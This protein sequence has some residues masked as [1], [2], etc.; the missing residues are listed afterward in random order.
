LTSFDGRFVKNLNGRIYVGWNI[1]T[2]YLLDVQGSAWNVVY[3]WNPI[4][5]MNV[6]GF[7]NV[8]YGFVDSIRHYIY[9]SNNDS[10]SETIITGPT[11]LDPANIWSDGDNIY[12]SYNAIQLVLNKQTHIW[13]K[14]T[15][16]GITSFLGQ[17]VWSDGE[18]CYYSAD[19]TQ[20]VL[21]KE[22]SLWYTT[23]WTGITSFSR[24]KIWDDGESIY[25]TNGLTSYKLEKSSS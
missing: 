10:W 24:A 5:L 6:F 16:S 9:N 3:N 23:S 11:S 13:Q 8:F 22:L 15:W 12:Y 17:N 25:Y 20:Y 19:S 14:K 21:N 1:N 7:N 2:A 18:T 4:N